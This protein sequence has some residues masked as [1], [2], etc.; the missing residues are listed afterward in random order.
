M[1]PNFTRELV[2]REYSDE[3]VLKILGGN[4]MRVFETVLK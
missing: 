3:D 1:G 2:R 4:H